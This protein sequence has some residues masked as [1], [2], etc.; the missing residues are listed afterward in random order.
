MSRLLTSVKVSSSFGAAA[1]YMKQLF[2][3]L[4]FTRISIDD[5]G[6]VWPACC[7]DWV[8]FPLGNVFKQEWDDI[9]HG[10]AATRFRNSMF[11]GSLRY[12]NREWCPNIADAEAGIR[13]YHV[14]PLS[15]SPRTW[16]GSGP[17]HVNLN[18]DQTCN[19]KCPSC[20]HDF[21][22]VRGN[23]L[24]RI[25]ELQSFVE[26]RILPEVESVA[27]TGVGDPFMSRV[28][29][30]FLIDFDITKYPA[31]KT[32][33]F[34]TNGQL[35]DERMYA[36]MPGIHGLRLSVD[37]SID[38]AGPEVYGKVRPPGDW[39][40][41][42]RNL[43]FIKNIDNLILLGIS[44]VVQPA[45]FREMPAFVKLGES[46]VSGG[47][48][49]FVEFKRP[50][51]YSHLS[52]EEFSQLDIGQLPPDEMTLF[53]GIL[54][55]IERKRLFNARRGILP[56]INHNLQEFLPDRQSFQATAWERLKS[57]AVRW[58]PQS[59]RFKWH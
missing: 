46:L 32:I 1:Y 48:Q 31:L 6:N 20:R 15:E 36:K 58:S 26:A 3:K 43:Q 24:D 5:G 35:F 11:D 27:L 23:E 59:H 17:N 56:A 42:M 22:H 8:E 21:L 28:F 52:E 34:H 45:N 30:N 12:C 44:M 4:P 10:D 54:T 50:R 47:R 55:E 18:Y 40:L 38:A 37:I 13:N 14:V 16:N 25:K 19:L 49:T 39:T 2:C 51:N 33:H 7:P 41:L 57:A 53:Q 29:R 9:W